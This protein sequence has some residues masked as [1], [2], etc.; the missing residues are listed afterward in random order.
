M[1]RGVWG[2]RLTDPERLEGR[3]GSERVEVLTGRKSPSAG[4]H[5]AQ[6]REF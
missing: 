1:R 2:F 4:R 6:E 3:T 5:G